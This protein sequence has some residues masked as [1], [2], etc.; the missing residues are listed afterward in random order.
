MTSLSES[1]D[2]DA[3][4]VVIERLLA[5]FTFGCTGSAQDWVFRAVDCVANIRSIKSL[6]DKPDVLR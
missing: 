5:S 1:F 3:L 2:D 6:L 4:C